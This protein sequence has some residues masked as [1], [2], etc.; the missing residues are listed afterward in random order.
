MLSADLRELLADT[1]GRAG[2]DRN[3]H[4]KIVSRRV[5]SR[6]NARMTLLAMMRWNSLFMLAGTFALCQPS[7]F[8]IPDLGRVDGVIRGGILAA[9]GRSLF[10]WGSALREWDVTDGK[11]RKPLLL[12]PSRSAK[13]VASRM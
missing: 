6:Y 3:C 7:S 10:T 12:R 4:L 13:A 9:D 2:D 11:T 1:R 5:S 8:V